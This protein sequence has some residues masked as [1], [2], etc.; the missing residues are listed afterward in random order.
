VRLKRKKADDRQLE[1]DIW[2]VLYKMS[3]KELN[4]DRNFTLRFSETTPPRQLDVLAKDDQTVFIVECTHSRD[5]GP[6]SVKALIDK[7]NAIR[8]DV[9][10]AIHRHYGRTPALKVKFAIATKN[11]GWRLADRENCERTSIAVITEDDLAY[12]EK[13]TGFLKDA[14]RYQFLGRYLEGEGVDGLRDRVPATKGRMGGQIFY[15]FLMSPHDLLKIAYISH[16]AKTSIDDLGTYQRMVKPARLKAIGRYIDEG[17]KFPTNIVVN[18]KTSGSLH[19]DIGKNFGDTATGILHLPGLYGSASVIDGQ[20]RLYGYAH[21]SR[22][23]ENDRSVLSVLAYENLPLKDEIT[24]FVDIN[25]EQVK[26]PRSL[27]NEIISTLN[28]DDPDPTKRLDALHAR[29]V[30]RLDEFPSSPVR[31]RI[32]TVSQDK[33]HIRCLTL[34]SCV[35]GLSENNFLGTIQRAS[36]REYGTIDPGPLADLSD[37]RNRTIEK[38]VVTISKYLNLFAEPL[39]EHWRLGDDKGG[40]L[41]TNLGIR[42]LLLLLRKVISFIEGHEGVRTVTM[43]P[44]EIIDYVRPYIKHVV[45]WFENANPNDIAVYRNRGSSLLSVSQNC[46]QLMSIIHEADPTFRTRE[47]TEY[48]NNQDV[49]GTKQAKDLLDE[50]NR[51]IFDDVIERL[52]AKYGTARD[53]WWMQGVPKNIRIDCD[54]RFN[55][56]DGERDRHQFLTFSNYATIVQHG[57]NWAE[58]KEYYSFPERGKRKKSD[59]IAWIQRLIIA[60]NITH[61]VEKGP[62]SKE[63]VA[64][65]RQIHRLVRTHIKGR[66]QLVPGQVFVEPIGRSDVA[67]EDTAEAAE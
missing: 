12:F 48:I 38:T 37:N 33:D 20:H 55:N 1:D 53:A 6:R 10:N 31:D 35:D 7:I 67:S 23:E 13:L 24:L 47:L 49:E 5:S 18:L 60:R 54:E 29:I 45:D 56:S 39:E 62:L 42:A 50:I 51:V 41:C 46:F 40:Y 66:E 58:F 28:I 32:Q 3:F 4:Q 14:A 44:E 8:P 2:C 63:Q 25:T 16:R 34:T 61:H 57:D 17:G 15:N 59:Q 9:M 22:S 43:R 27:V 26:V 52:K 11:I 30:M 64:Y 21:A 19:F 36:R 65:V